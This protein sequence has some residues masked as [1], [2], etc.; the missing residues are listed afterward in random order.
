MITLSI[1][2]PVAVVVIVALIALWYWRYTKAGPNEVLVVS[3]RGKYRFVRG[4]TFVWPILERVQ[5][6][7]LSL[8]TLDVNASDAYT[9]QGVKLM[10]DAV[11]QV[12][13]RSA[14]DSIQ[15]AA[16]QFLG[17]PADEIRRVALQ[18]IEGYVRAILGTISVEDI[19]LTR[20]EF[21]QKVKRGA[22]ADLDPMGLQIVSL[23]IRHIDDETG[24]LEA[25]G[26]PRVAQVKRDAIIGESKAEEEAMAARYAADV[27]IA[28][29]R[30]DKEIKESE[31]SAEVATVK[32]E[33]D[34]AYDLQKFR[35]QQDVKREEIAV[36]LVAKDQEIVLQEKETE[37]KERELATDV[38]KPA[39]AERYRIETLAQAE[40]LRLETEAVGQAESI[41]QQGQ[42]EAEALKAKGVAEAEA[43]RQK[44]D[45]WKE[46]N[47]AA[48]TERIVGILPELA[49]K[50]A[51]PL[52]KTERIVVLGGGN[53]QNGTGA[54]KVTQDVAQI[55]AG[56]PA[57]VEGLTGVQLG[58][59]VKAVPQLGRNGGN[60]EKT[61][62]DVEVTE[63]K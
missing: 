56:L 48:V 27:A 51:E 34:L 57:V 6:L 61:E 29:A 58:D 54:H 18:V 25:L 28:L 63:I 4:G 24:Y 52:S 42:A 32:A 41:R 5:T 35:K 45:S 38:M 53:G 9:K 47:Q 22:Q 15:Q 17:K 16:E 21:A 2:I 44:A 7:S 30:R 1:I 50:V 13:V 26:K 59:L 62:E 46:Y 60:T 20:E 49:G 37:R 11:A 31:Y 19:Y 23:T 39:D 14:E 8:L 10:V 40:K 55:I 36:Q 12:K 3:G 33:S 43:M